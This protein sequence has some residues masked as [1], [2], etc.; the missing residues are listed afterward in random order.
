MFIFETSSWCARIANV[1]EWHTNV[2][3]P[4]F[5]QR[6]SR[7]VDRM[8]V[9]LGQEQMIENLFQKDLLYANNI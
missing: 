2:C 7:H 3:R 4:T 1:R 9:D 6:L 8:L 5:G